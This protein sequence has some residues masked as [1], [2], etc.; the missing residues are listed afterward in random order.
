MKDFA[1]GPRIFLALRFLDSLVSLTAE[2]LKNLLIFDILPIFM[3]RGVKGSI[4]VELT[5]IVM[6]VALVILVTNY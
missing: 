4:I 3:I 1:T 6:L 5:L 2:A